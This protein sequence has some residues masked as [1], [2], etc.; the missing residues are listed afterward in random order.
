MK[1]KINKDT[2]EEPKYCKIHLKNNFLTMVNVFTGS[3]S[4]FIDSREFMKISDKDLQSVKNQL[5]ENNRIVL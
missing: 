4:L 1:L 2:L 3:K 5:L